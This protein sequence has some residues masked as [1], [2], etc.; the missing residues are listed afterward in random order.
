MVLHDAMV[1]LLWRTYFSLFTCGSW[2]NG[3]IT[4]IY[5]HVKEENLFWTNE[6]RVALFV[7]FITLW[8]DSMKMNQ[9]WKWQEEE[10]DLSITEH[11]IQNT[12]ALSNVISTLK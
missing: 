8:S 11:S 6:N 7:A 4:D 2:T 12:F 1:A 5:V 3:Q 9:I 10:N